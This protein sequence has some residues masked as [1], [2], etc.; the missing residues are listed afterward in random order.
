MNTVEL[1]INDL[2]P[3]PILLFFVIIINFCV[4]VNDAKGG[5]RRTTAAIACASLLFFSSFYQD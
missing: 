1:C 5:K 2:E 4:D 3:F